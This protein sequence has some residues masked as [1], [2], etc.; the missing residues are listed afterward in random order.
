M[1]VFDSET[2]EI[3]PFVFFVLGDAGRKL[4]T[5]SKQDVM[6]NRAT[7]AVL[8]VARLDLNVFWMTGLLIINTNMVEA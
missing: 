4:D 3:V 2:P 1:L 5:A 6:L 8:E 7:R